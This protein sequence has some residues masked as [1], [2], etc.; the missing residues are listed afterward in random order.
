MLKNDIVLVPFP[1]TNQEEFKV[2]PAVIISNNEYNKHDDLIVCGITSNTEKQKYAIP[3]L[4]LKIPSVVRVD[5]LLRIDKQLVHK[6]IGAIKQKTAN[7]IRKEL[8]NLI[9]NK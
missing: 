1:F 8:I 3:L 2:R 4:D 7:Q 9:T 5:R 6:K